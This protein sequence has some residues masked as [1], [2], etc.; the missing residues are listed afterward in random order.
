MGAHAVRKEELPV[1]TEDDIFELRHM[2]R[3]LAQDYEFDSFAIAALT[4]AASELGRNI[5]THAHHGT[6]I[7]EILEDEQESREA[8]RMIFTDDGPGIADVEKALAGG[9][10]TANSLGLGL[11]GTKRLVDEFEIETQP[12]KGTVVRVMKWNRTF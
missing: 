7:I 4:T 1:E 9:H 5:W 3:S 12:G 6:A 11:S 8:I 10:S 2:V